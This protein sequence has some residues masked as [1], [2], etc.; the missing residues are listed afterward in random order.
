MVEV[1]F[2]W[3]LT[4]IITLASVVS[5]LA[6]IIYKLISTRLKLQDAKLEANEILIRRLQGEISS[7]SSGCGLPGCLY[8]PG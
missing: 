6:I 1:P 7:L 5:S 3:I 8:K 4:A 2:E